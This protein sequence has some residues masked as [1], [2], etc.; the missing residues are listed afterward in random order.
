VHEG[1][2]RALKKA[3]PL[4]FFVNADYLKRHAP[5]LRELLR[6]GVFVVLVDEFRT[7][8]YCAACSGQ[9]SKL[10]ESVERM[11]C[12]ECARGPKKKRFTAAAWADAVRAPGSATTTTAPGA[13][14]AAPGAARAGGD[15]DDNEHDAA[16]APGAASGAAVRDAVRAEFKSIQRPQRTDI[17]R[18][19]CTLLGSNKGEN[20]T[21]HAGLSGSGVTHSI[22]TRVPDLPPVGN[23]LPE[24]D[25]V[26]GA[27]AY[28]RMVKLSVLSTANLR[29]RLLRAIA[30]HRCEQCPAADDK[31]RCE[32]CRWRR[33]KHRLPHCIVCHAD[34]DDTCCVVKEQVGVWRYKYCKRCDR[35]VHRDENAVDNLFLT[36]YNLFMAISD[37]DDGSAARPYPLWCCTVEGADRC[38]G[39]T[40]VW[41]QEWDSLQQ[42]GGASGVVAGAGAAS[43]VGG[44]SAGAGASASA[45]ARSAVAGAG[46]SLRGGPSADAKKRFVQTNLLEMFRK[47]PSPSPSTIAPTPTIVVVVDEPPQPPPPPLPQ[48]PPPDWFD[49]DG[50]YDDKVQPP[51]RSTLPPPLP[52]P[53]PPPLTTPPPMTIDVDAAHALPDSDAC[54]ASEFG[55][56]APLD[57]VDARHKRRRTDTDTNA[58][59]NI[60]NTNNTSIDFTDNSTTNADTINSTSIANTD[61]NINNTNN[62]SIDFTDNST[63]NADTINST[64]IA[65]TDI[66]INNTNNTSIDFTS[67]D[68][69]DN[70]TANADTIN[71]TASIANADNSTDADS[72]YT[73]RCSSTASASVI[74]ETNTDA[75]GVTTIT[76]TTTTTAIITDV[77]NNTT[78]TVS[79][80]TIATT[81]ITAAGVTSSTSIDNISIAPSIATS[82]ANNTTASNNNNTCI[83]NNNNTSNNLKNTER[84]TEIV[85]P[86][87]SNN[88][89]S[90]STLVGNPRA[91]T[92]ATSSSTPVPASLV[93][94][95]TDERPAQ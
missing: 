76:T 13:A 35:R 48:P 55:G 33:L 82:I 39:A 16:A 63:T 70:S 31:P 56:A 75:D 46:V 92:S 93:D 74:C 69:T 58:N 40:F 25:V 94:A 89:N 60:N 3:N 11:V 42:D 47:K 36:V 73:R 67:I 91:S 4:V 32:Q 61:I 87:N 71:S 26:R 37:N 64:S 28:Q 30:R 5:I 21:V 68:F 24:I 7:S 1:V 15:H 14:S 19:L 84:A 27:F 59:N 45:V 18:L 41:R 22:A 9:L 8:E 78:R 90:V 10:E 43:A 20:T 85:Y 44:A 77:A 17:V 53:S 50:D 80:I 88:S 72:N 79:R 34:A 83:N 2:A 66:N 51:P 52:P 29:R 57:D 95:E 6:L 86:T 62:T 49:P 23:A 38:D 54:I 65:N 12:D 81:T